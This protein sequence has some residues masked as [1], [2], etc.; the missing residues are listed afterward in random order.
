Q[1]TTSTGESDMA[2]DSPPAHPL[3]G[4][5]IEDDRFWDA[6]GQEILFSAGDPTEEQRNTLLL[7]ARLER[8]LESLES[9]QN[10]VLGAGS[11]SLYDSDCE[12]TDPTVSEMVAEMQMLG[13]EDSDDDESDAGD[14]R[15][16]EDANFAPHGSKT[17][18]MLDTLDNLPRLR[19]SDDHMK[20]ILW[21]MRE[22]RTPNVPSFSA[23]RRK[24]AELTRQVNITPRVHTSALGNKFYM[25]HPLDLLALVRKFLLNLSQHSEC[26]RSRIGQTPVFGN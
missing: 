21:V 11:Q 10:P 9:G 12:D 13:F 23:L 22:C 25:N 15:I 14:A 24:Q 26:A 18:F 4:F 2:L 6:D 7:R 3:D 17:M 16:D 1:F 5:V 20:T 19:L 8:D